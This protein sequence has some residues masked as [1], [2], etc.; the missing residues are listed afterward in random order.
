[1]VTKGRYNYDYIQRFTIRG[2]TGDD[3]LSDVPTYTCCTYISLPDV[4]KIW[5]SGS[6]LV[7]K[8]RYNYDYIQRFTI[9]GQT[10][11]DCLSDVL[12]ST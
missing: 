7:T 6:I 8:G 4:L 2:Q 1:M 10:G 9:R 11:D 12:T 5:R 3:C